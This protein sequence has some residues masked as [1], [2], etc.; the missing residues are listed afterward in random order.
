MADNRFLPLFL[1]LPTSE[2]QFLIITT[3]MT[4]LIQMQFLHHCLAEPDHVFW[5]IFRL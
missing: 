1:N 3:I 2:K 5:F 4:S